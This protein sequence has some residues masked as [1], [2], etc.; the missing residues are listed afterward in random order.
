MGATPTGALFY[1]KNLTEKESDV[2]I[3]INPEIVKIKARIPEGYVV[4]HIRPP[5]DEQYYDYQKKLL[6][7]SGKRNSTG[8]PER[9]NRVSR[10]FVDSLLIDVS[11][12]DEDG[13]PEEFVYMDSNGQTQLLN[14]LVENWKSYI[15]DKV[16]TATAVTLLQ[17]QSDFD[18]GSLKN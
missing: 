6:R 9:M 11:A 5:S 15:P 1:F 8:D 13:N 4:M 10:E 3:L 12:R 7:I 17:D 16:K 14:N 2:S 18:R